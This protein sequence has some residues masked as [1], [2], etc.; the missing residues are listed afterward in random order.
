MQTLLTEDDTPGPRKESIRCLFGLRPVEAPVSEQ[1]TPR[2][3]T[4]VTE[5]ESVRTVPGVTKEEISCDR[6]A[7]L[8]R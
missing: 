4:H 7:A 5:L 8:E 3:W 6:L 2:D 1:H